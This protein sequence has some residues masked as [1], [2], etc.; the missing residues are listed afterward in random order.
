MTERGCGS[1]EEKALYV[2]VEPHEEGL[3]IEHF[4]LDPAPEWTGDV[5]LRSPFLVESKDGERNHMVLGVGKKHYPTVPDFVEEARKLA[6]SKRIP[7]DFD[8]SQL[9]QGESYIILMHPR[10]IPTFDYEV[11][12]GCMRSSTAEHECI[13]KLWP[14]SALEGSKDSHHIV[15]EGD[16]LVRIKIPCGRSYTVEKPIEPGKEKY[17]PTAFD[18]GL[19][20]RLPITRFEFVNS[21]GEIPSEIKETADATEW[22]VVVC[23]E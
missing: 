22:E 16:G 20:L 21:E 4:L 19:F 1:R 10:A 9:T 7:R 15:E 14:L 23:D 6:V 3:P 12:R 8:F 13:H 18:P 17:Q 5:P 2:K 11:K